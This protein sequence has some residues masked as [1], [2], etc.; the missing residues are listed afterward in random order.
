MQARAAREEARRAAAFNALPQEERDSLFAAH[1]DSLVASQADS[2]SA[3]DGTP[4]AADSLQRATVRKP[5][6]A[7]GI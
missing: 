7:K 3:A 1:I 6:A 5:R 2:L 4:P